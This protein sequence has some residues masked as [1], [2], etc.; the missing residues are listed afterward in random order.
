[1]SEK[2]IPAI[3]IPCLHSSVCLL[4]FDAGHQLSDPAGP[5]MS[6][7]LKDA[8]RRHWMSL[9]GAATMTVLL[10]LMILNPK[11]ERTF[12][13]RDPKEESAGEP[14]KFNQPLTAG[15]VGSL[16][17]KHASKLL[18]ERANMQ[19]PSKDLESWNTLWKRLLYVVRGIN[20][21]LNFPRIKENLLSVMCRLLF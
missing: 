4:P 8:P 18:T 12:R 5:K 19:L 10:V 13:L 21:P 1:M 14:D 2:C 11:K 7:V 17:F 6:Q 20:V 9:F 16:R 15:R 3:L